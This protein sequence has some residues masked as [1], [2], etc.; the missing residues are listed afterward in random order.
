MVKKFTWAISETW[1]RDILDI[2]YLFSVH[3]MEV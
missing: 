1:F 2:V 3:V